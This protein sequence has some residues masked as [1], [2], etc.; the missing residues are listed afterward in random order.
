MYSFHHII[1]TLIKNAQKLCS[2]LYFINFEGENCSKYI[3]P[4]LRDAILYIEISKFFSRCW[5]YFLWLFKS[6]IFVFRKLKNI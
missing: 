4:S 1:Y 2:V 5:N 6:C 3:P